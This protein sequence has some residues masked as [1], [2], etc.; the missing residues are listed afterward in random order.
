MIFG[1]VNVK[2]GNYFNTDIMKEGSTSNMIKIHAMSI[3]KN[4]YWGS[5]GKFWNYF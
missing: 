2:E 4:D 3:I 5:F 1:H